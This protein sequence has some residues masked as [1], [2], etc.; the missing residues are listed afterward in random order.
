MLTSASNRVLRAG[1][2]CFPLLPSTLTQANCK[3]RPVE[4]CCLNILR[5]F[6]ATETVML[7]FS[8]RMVALWR[9]FYE[10]RTKQLS[11]VIDS[12]LF[13]LRIV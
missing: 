7:P 4:R 13:T 6:S 9:L 8:R 3:L 11:I 2:N 10:I 1:V 12:S 5:H